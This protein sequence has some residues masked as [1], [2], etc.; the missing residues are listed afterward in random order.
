VKKRYDSVIVG[1]GVAGYALAALAAQA[2]SVL[3]FEND[4]PPAEPPWERP[5]V[6]VEPGSVW[7][8][9]NAA[10]PLEGL[11]PAP[12]RFQSLAGRDRT[13]GRQAF[14]VAPPAADEVARWFAAQVEWPK[15][16][17]RAWR[18]LFGQPGPEQ[19]EL[20]GPVLAHPTGV[21]SRD[22]GVR[23][24]LALQA[25]NLSTP[26]GST[27]QL[28]RALRAAA[29]KDGADFLPIA[30]FEGLG[31]G[32]VRVE[33]AGRVIETPRIGVCLDLGQWTQAPGLGALPRKVFSWVR[34]EGVRVRARW[35][36]DE[37]ELPVGLAGRGWWSDAPQA[38]FEVT[39]QGAQ[40]VLSAWALESAGAEVDGRDVARRLLD[41]VR[42]YVPFFRGSLDAARIAVT[43]VWR[44]AAR[45]GRGAPPRLGPFAYAGPQSFPGWGL[46][47]ELA[48]AL[49]VHRMW[50]PPVESAA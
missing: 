31:R 43:P 28:L 46:E 6:G 47:G 32:G 26:S 30:R 38:F 19:A 27:P 1:G 42:R 7:A 34:P 50:F 20:P 17:L 36:C 23:A 44:S 41:V 11:T 13:D 3:Y 12:F 16:Y 2:G 29:A 22:P 45:G 49:R 21:V 25:A 10:V 24:Y 5:L 39:G 37:G 8:L 48:A 9:F 15:W 14:A 33:G 18:R 35:T 4:E 40:T